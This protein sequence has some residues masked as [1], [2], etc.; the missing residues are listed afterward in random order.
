MWVISSL[1]LLYVVT[2][3]FKATVSVGVVQSWLFVSQHYYFRNY[4]LFFC[5]RV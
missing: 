1:V 5:R 4:Y 2:G 3:G